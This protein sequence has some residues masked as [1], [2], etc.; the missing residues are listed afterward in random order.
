[1]NPP[2]P[3]YSRSSALALRRHATAWQVWALLAL[4]LAFQGLGQS[5]RV[6]HGAGFARALVPLSSL[7]PVLASAGAKVGTLASADGW[8]HQRGEL[9]CLLLDQLSHDHASLTQ[10]VALLPDLPE[11][12]PAAAQIASLHLAARWKRAARG[13][14]LVV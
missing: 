5:H 4:M 10:P 2:R 3:P 14:P 7:A 6:L 8:G 12:V 11:V 1:M 13:P 9:I